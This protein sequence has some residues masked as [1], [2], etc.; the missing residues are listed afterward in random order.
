MHQ[1]PGRSLSSG[2]PYDP[3]PLNKARDGATAP[4]RGAFDELRW[5]T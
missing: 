1:V 2:S 4:P 3:R 5:G